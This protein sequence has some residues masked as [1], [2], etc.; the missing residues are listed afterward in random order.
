MRMRYLDMIARK[1]Y[2]MRSR[3]LRN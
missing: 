2:Y 3:S 1:I